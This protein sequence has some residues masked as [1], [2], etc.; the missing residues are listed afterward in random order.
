M[1]RHAF[2]FNRRELIEVNREAMEVAMR[3]RE[4]WLAENQ[5][6]I[7]AYNEHVAQHGVFSAGLRAF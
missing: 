4:I 1:T 3:Q 2:L 5:E 7:Q 6:A